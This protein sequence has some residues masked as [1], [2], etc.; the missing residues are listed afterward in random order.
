MDLPP[1]THAPHPRLTAYY[2]DEPGRLARVRQWFDAAAGDYDRI[3]RLMSFGSGAHYRG[4]ALRRL[5]VKAGARLLDV[6]S[7]TG[8]IAG[9]AQK[10]V[11]DSGLVVAVDPSSGMLGQ[12]RARGVSHIVPGR[13]ESLPFADASFDLL[14]MGYALR[15]VADLDAAFREYRRVL[16]PGGRVLLLEITRPRSAAGTRAL[17]WYMHA[18]VPRLAR[19]RDAA[20]LM[21]YYWDTIEQCVAP[22]VILASLQA[23]GFAGASRKIAFSIFSEYSAARPAL[24][25]L[26]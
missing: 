24:S 15:H 7:G 16:R 20:E 21:R 23:A 25:T 22:E 9:L 2:A 11:G 19:S 17:R 1:P 13:G 18:L 14:T 8:V 12:A 3:N 5:G 6:G 26:S 10:L 4:D